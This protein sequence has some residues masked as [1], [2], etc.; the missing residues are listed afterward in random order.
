MVSRLYRLGQD[1]DIKFVVSGIASLENMNLAVTA[2]VYDS[3]GKQISALLSPSVVERTVRLVV[4][5]NL[6]AQSGDY[7]VVFAITDGLKPPQDI[8]IY[9][10]VYS[11]E[12][13]DPLPVI[14]LSPESTDNEVETALGMGTRSERRKGTAKEANATT[15]NAIRDKTGRDMLPSELLKQKKLKLSR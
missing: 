5:S 2:K 3:E 14:T 6:I 8:P 10:A 15:L 13:Q 4:P 7:V 1:I 12:G 9:F 11:H